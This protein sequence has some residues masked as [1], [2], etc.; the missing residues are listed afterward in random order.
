MLVALGIDNFGS[1]LFLPLPVLYAI[2]VA[3]LP[4]ATAGT[5]V[6]IGTTM[7]LLAPPM[8]GLLVDRVG[9][10]LV[11]IGSQL[12][13]AA[14]AVVYL[15][16]ANAVTVLV[17]TL[18]LASGQQAFYSS[19]SILIADTARPGHKDHAFAVVSM[20]RGA[21]IGLGGLLAA[22]VLAGA[23]GAG[24]R[25]AVGGDGVSFLVAALLLALLVRMPYKRH[26]TQTAPIGVLRN[27]PFLTLIAVTGM[28][29]V[30]VDFFMVGIPVYV[31]EVLHGPPWL[32]GAMLAVLTILGTLAGTVVVRLTSHLWRTTAMSY[33]AV[34]CV[35]WCVASLA[36]L[37]VP[38]EWRPGYLLAAVL[39]LVA[40]NLLSRR[41]NALA[42][43]AAPRA[44]RGRYM[45]AFQYAFTGAG[46]VAPGMV[47]LFSAGVWL[48]WLIVAVIAAASAGALPYLARRLPYHA[49]TG[50]EPSTTEVP[51][52]A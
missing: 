51:E 45:A 23:G 16:A 18:L 38:A 14:G 32:P 29:A 1:G 25:I 15:M 20:V 31:I 27:G 44:I 5:V 21:C 10:R 3:G 19:L 40:A 46:V 24:Y 26:N 50:Q 41:A 36:A 47:A 37:V 4:I 9:P 42:E 48:P 2:R 39:P 17:A 6:T 34:L 13:Q 11:V 28:F 52:V 35:L 7:G 33:G 12:I 30:A 8:A 22:G 49:V 43:A